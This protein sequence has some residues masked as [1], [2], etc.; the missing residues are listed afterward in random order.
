MLLAIN[1]KIEEPLTQQ[2]CLLEFAA[3]AVKRAQGFGDARNSAQ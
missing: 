2:I 3:T 1:P